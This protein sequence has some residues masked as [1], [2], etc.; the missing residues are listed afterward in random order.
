MNN[1]ISWFKNKMKIVYF[2]IFIILFTLS[3]DFWGWNQSKPLIL[4]LPF[5]IYYLLFLTIIISGFFYLITKSIWR[6]DN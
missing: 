3:L 6:E 5:W 4:G 1:K 2:F